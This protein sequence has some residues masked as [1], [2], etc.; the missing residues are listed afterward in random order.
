MKSLVSSQIGSEQSASLV[1]SR[2]Y[3]WL[4][5]SRALIFCVDFDL[6]LLTLCLVSSILGYFFI[7]DLFFFGW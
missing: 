1:F 7:V 4:F 6:L 5:S 2:L 3:F